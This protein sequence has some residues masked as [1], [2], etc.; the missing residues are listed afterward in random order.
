MSLDGLIFEVKKL[1]LE[2]SN[3]PDR[4]PESIDDRASL[5]ADG[6]GL[7]SIDVLELVVALDKRYGLKIKNDQKGREVLHNVRSI[8]EAIFAK[9]NA[10]A[11]S[12]SAGL[13]NSPRR[14][15]S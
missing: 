7:D 13:Q 5:F 12:P 4:T 9:N 2:L 11:A 1:L 6:L 3:L 14:P 8:A 10:S 15:V